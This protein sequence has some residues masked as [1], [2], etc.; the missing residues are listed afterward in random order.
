MDLD[1]HN[2]LLATPEAFRKLRVPE[3]VE[4][5]VEA[6]KKRSIDEDAFVTLLPLRSIRDF[7]DTEFRGS[8]GHLEVI[9]EGGR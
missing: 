4:K 5:E 2:Y 9:P 1:L 6:P 7:G 8:Q 3:T